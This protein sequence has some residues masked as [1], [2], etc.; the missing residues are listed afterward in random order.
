MFGGNEFMKRKIAGIFVCMLLFLTVLPVAGLKTGETN[1]ETQ[2][3]I[4]RTMYNDLLV[5]MQ[6]E[7]GVTV[8]FEEEK[9]VKIFQKIKIGDIKRI[10]SDAIVESG[11]MESGLNEML[12]ERFNKLYS[13]GVGDD[14]S[15]HDLFSGDAL[16]MP[17]DEFWP[18]PLLVLLLNLLHFNVVCDVDVYMR[19]GWVINESEYS[20]NIS[21][22]GGRILIGAKGWI[23]TDM[24]IL[25]EALKDKYPILAEIIDRLVPSRSSGHL[26]HWI[27]GLDLT[28]RVDSKEYIKEY[29]LE[30]GPGLINFIKELINKAKS[31]LGK[32]ELYDLKAKALFVIG[33]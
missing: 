7:D 30:L 23:H 33:I 27:I 6:R 15:L 19:D 9:L 21:K 10:F 17:S 28:T 14:I 2:K 12:Q 4:V 18:Y 22:E 16:N 8:N 25:S 3:T 31:A 20:A 26:M 24:G 1:F 13:L 32:K 5:Q 29:D 11:S